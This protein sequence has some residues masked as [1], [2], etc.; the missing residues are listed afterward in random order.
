MRDVRADFDGELR[1][2][3]GEPSM[4]TSPT[5][6]SRWLTPSWRTAPRAC[7]PAAGGRSSRTCAATTVRQSALARVALRRVGRR[8]PDHCPAPV[9]RTAEP[10]RPT[11]S[12]PA[13]FTTGLTAG[14]LAAIL[15][16]ARR[17]PGQHDGQGHTTASMVQVEVLTVRNDERPG[18]RNPDG[19]SR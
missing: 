8:H 11:G 15:V 6:R 18:R 2:F 7:L 17:G 9:H 10:S 1:E 16:A 14:A 5:S 4:C 12:R 3:N 19:C 13:T